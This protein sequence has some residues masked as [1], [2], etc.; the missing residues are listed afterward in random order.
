MMLEYGLLFF[1]VVGMITTM[2]IY[3]KRSMQA[4]IRDARVYMFKSVQ[5]RTAGY[6]SGNLY[7][8]YEPYYA[9]TT[10]TVDRGGSENVYLVPTPGLS[11]GIFRKVFSD[12]IIVNTRSETAPPVN[13]IQDKH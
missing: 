8:E 10:S 13:A 6:Y 11:S 4:R 5:N 3:F 7:V 12:T 9:N 1:L 2:T